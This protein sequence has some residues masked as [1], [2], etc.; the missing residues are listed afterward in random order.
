MVFT[1]EQKMIQEMVGKL[2]KDKIEPLVKETDMSS[3]SS[4][5]IIKLLAKNDLLKIALPEKY[6]GI[7]A[8]HT[9]IAMVVEEVARVDASTAMILFVTQSLIQI[10]KQWGS[11]ETF[12][13][14]QMKT[15]QINIECYIFFNTPKLN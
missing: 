10:L 11:E 8:D 9:T 15:T 3:H 2:A 14:H 6:G 4:P 7:G 1:E 13:F 5:E 12:K